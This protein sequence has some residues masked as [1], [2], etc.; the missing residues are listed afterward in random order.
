MCSLEHEAPFRGKHSCFCAQKAHVPAL[1]QLPGK[2]PWGEV[3][4]LGQHI[5][6]QEGMELE[7]GRDPL[8]QAHQGILTQELSP[9]VSLGCV[10]LERIES[11]AGRR[12][13]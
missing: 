7:K 6:Q 3:H 12:A 4:T 11:T 8:V 2:I 13:C 1:T 5:R 9:Y 10:G